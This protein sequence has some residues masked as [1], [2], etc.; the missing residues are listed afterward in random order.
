[1]SSL[2]ST[3]HTLL[4]YIL[5]SPVVQLYV[6]SMLLFVCGVLYEVWHRSIHVSFLN[7]MSLAHVESTHPHL[8]STRIISALFFCVCVLFF[9]GFYRYFSISPLHE[10]ATWMVIAAL[11]IGSAGLVVWGE[12]HSKHAREYFFSYLIGN[13][14]ALLCLAGI[15]WI[16]SL[17]IAT[18]VWIMLV[19]LYSDLLALRLIWSSWSIRGMTITLL[20][21]FFWV[22]VLW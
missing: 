18:N 7:K 22:I 6:C 10:P 5:Q 21:F 16:S 1:M 13:A 9:V 3:F 15:S 14:S 8:P 12:L 20:S 4:V 17:S 11:F 2:L 19:L